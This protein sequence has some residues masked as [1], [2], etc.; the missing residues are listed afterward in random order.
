MTNIHASIE[1]PILGWG[2]RPEKDVRSAT[3]YMGL[4]NMGSTCYMNRLGTT[5]EIVPLE[6]EKNDPITHA[7]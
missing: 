2:N 5:L 4:R 7:S 3:G 6:I 1:Q